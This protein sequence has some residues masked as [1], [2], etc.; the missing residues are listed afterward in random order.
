[1]ATLGIATELLHAAGH[2][3]EVRDPSLYP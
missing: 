3:F 2:G 1:M